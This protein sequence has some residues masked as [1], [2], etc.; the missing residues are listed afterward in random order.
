LTA[1]IPEEGAMPKTIGGQANRYDFCL[2]FAD[3]QRRYVEEVAKLLH[4]HDIAVFYD[5]FES[6][7]LFGSDVPVRLHDVFNRLSRYCVM[8]VSADYVR[9]MWTNLERA[10]ALD[11]AL[12]NGAPYILVVRFDDARVPGLPDTIGHFDARAGSPAELV[13]RLVTKLERTPPIAAALSATI[14]VVGAN[15]SATTADDILD[16]ALERCGIDLPARHRTRLGPTAAAALPIANL[17]TLDTLTQVVPAIEWAIGKYNT[18]P[19]GSASARVRIGLHRGEIPD[20]TDWTCVDVSTAFD[21]VDATIV[22]DILAAAPRADCAVVASQRVYDDIIGPGLP[23]VTPSTYRRIT[24][25]KGSSAWVRVPGYPKP[26]EPSTPSAPSTV[27]AERSARRPDPTVNGQF[28]NNR[29]TNH[30]NAPFEVRQIGDNYYQAG[31][32]DD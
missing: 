8:F 2:S 31:S 5:S 32:S 9:K 28:N 24:L 10:S 23:G 21:A 12:R 4:R 30:F 17:S 19:I 14:L 27:S 11:R 3:E 20:G 6:A 1:V 29:T 13:D 7:D 16:L 18:S 26:P 25:P 15:E 22:R